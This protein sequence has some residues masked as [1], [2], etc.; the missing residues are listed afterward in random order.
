[1]TTT[2][3]IDERASQVTA[4]ESSTSSPAAGPSWEPG[5]S[6]VGAEDQKMGG[7]I[8]F[9]QSGMYSLSV[10]IREQLAGEDPLRATAWGGTTTVLSPPA[11]HRSAGEK[12]EQPP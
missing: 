2:A 6:P 3:D 8:R 7:R 9:A 4:S 10:A 5:W 12:R 11:S 1:M